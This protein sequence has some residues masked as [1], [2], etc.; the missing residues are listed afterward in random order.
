MAQ[1]S[2]SRCMNRAMSLCMLAR[3]FMYSTSSGFF[4]SGF[5]SV[6]GVSGLALT[7]S[8]VC[9]GFSVLLCRRLVASA[10]D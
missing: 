2:T 1:F 10:T 3:W 7:G 5:L 4:I 6:F 8:G 9:G